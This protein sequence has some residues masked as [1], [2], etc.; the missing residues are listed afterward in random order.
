MSYDALIL[1]IFSQFR[2]TVD[3]LY[4]FLIIQLRS[5]HRWRDYIEITAGGF[6]ELWNSFSSW[7]ERYGKTEI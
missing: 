1:S 6:T 7:I 4:K 2:M 5:V 3:R